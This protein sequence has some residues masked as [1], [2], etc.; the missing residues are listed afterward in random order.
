MIRPIKSYV[1]LNLT[2]TIIALL[3][4]CRIAFLYFSP[5]L[6]VNLTPSIPKGFYYIST[7]K[8][9][10]KGDFVAFHLPK[11]IRESLG[12]R[13]WLHP[14]YPF[15]K[16]IGAISKD[17]ICREGN[18]ITINTTQ[19]FLAS[20]KDSQELGLPTWSGCVEIKADFFLPIG[21]HSSSF[22]GRYFGQISN[23]QIIGQ[24]TP[25]LTWQ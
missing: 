9:P 3:V 19:L 13:S 7:E 10:K 5:V 20:K 25:L 17:L 18:E 1:A 12:G 8:K 11:K 21:Q 22:D 15:I 24:A 16:K 14:T 23:K 6:L 2:F 4:L